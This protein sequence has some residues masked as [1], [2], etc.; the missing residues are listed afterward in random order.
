M[1]DQGL[2]EERGARKAAE[3]RSRF[4]HISNRAFR[5]NRRLRVAGYGGQRRTN[6]TSSGR[7]LMVWLA[8]GLVAFAVGSLVA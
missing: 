6:L 7:A 2:N 3:L 4:K 5:S 8:I 1:S